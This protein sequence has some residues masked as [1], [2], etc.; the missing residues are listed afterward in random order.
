MDIHPVDVKNVTIE[1]AFWTERLRQMRE[2]VIPYQWE[3]LNDRI[4]EAEKSGAVQNVRIAAG[5][6]KGDFY[7]PP[8]QDSD[9]AKWLEA[10]SYLLASSPDA[11]LERTIDEL[12]DLIRSAQ[13]EDGYID[14]YYIIRDRDARW[15]NLRDMHELYVMGHLTEAAVA[16]YDA[17]GK[18]TL[19]E[20]AQ[21]AADLM[22]RVFGRGRGKIRGYPGH[23]EIE[24]ALVKLYRATGEK[25]YLKLAQYFIDERGRQPCYFIKEAKKRGDNPMGPWGSG[26]PEYWQAHAPVREQHTAEGHAVRAMYLFAAMADIAQ[27]TGEE[28]LKKSCERLWENVVRKRMYI[29]GGVGSSH[30]GE[31]FTCDYDLPNESAYAETCAA[32]GLVFFAHRMLHLDMDARYADVMERALYN[33]VL[34]GVSLDGKHYFYVNPLASFPGVGKPHARQK[35]YGCACCPPN[36]ARLMTSLGTYAYSQRTDSLFVHLYLGGSVR[37]DVGDAPVEFRMKTAYPWKEKVTCT[38]GCKE[39][40]QFKLHLRMPGWCDKPRIK[41]NG[42]KINIK[43]KMLKNGYL[44]IDRTWKD[45]DKITMRLPMPVK[46]MESHP[47]VRMN[48]GRVAIQRGPVVYCI[49]EEDNGAGLNDI[50]LKIKAKFRI[51]SGSGV[52]SGVPVIRAKGYRRSLSGWKKKLYQAAGSPLK[53]VKITAIPYA[54]WANR[55]VGEML[56]WIRAVK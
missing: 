38:L 14:T 1:G 8:F 29:I 55:K 43:K 20:V 49:E 26:L 7:G 24:L 6:E 12:I 5:L 2:I 37:F 11:D 9:L 36:L 53:P 56:V 35:W 41:L 19:L 33:N 16:H 22:I 32:I 52:L 40:V 45:G 46:C 3:L 47:E 28:E 39:P 23:E 31:R 15:T 25:K 51:K 48:A 13:E 10:A 4:P 21:R 27:E 44:V 30:D 34:S 42:E 18:T 50:M 54:L 17:T